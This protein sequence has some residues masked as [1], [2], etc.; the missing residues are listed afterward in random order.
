MKAVYKQSVADLEMTGLNLGLGKVPLGPSEWLSKI[1]GFLASALAVSLGAP[2]WF[3]VLQ[4]FM[5]VR[6]TGG[7]PKKK[8]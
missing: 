6:G 2:F 5:Q 1:A 8:T 7:T 4:R 3:L